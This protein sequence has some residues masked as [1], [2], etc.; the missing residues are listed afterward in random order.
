MDIVLFLDQFY[1]YNRF[2]GHDV[3]PNFLKIINQYLLKSN[4][5]TNLDQQA[6]IYRE[7]NKVYVVIN[8]IY[9][10]N[11]EPINSKSKFRYFIFLSFTFFNTIEPLICIARL[12][13]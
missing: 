1:R 9:K 7:D 13:K 2:V 8:E 3:N 12:L 6:P 4:Q 5:K 11:F 10:V